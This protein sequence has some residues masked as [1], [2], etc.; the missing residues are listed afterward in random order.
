VVAG[1]VDCS[2]DPPSV[3]DGTWPVARHDPAGTRS[4]PAANGPAERPTRRWTVDTVETG[5]GVPVADTEAVYAFA[6]GGPVHPNGEDDHPTDAVAVRA[7]RSGTV[8]WRFRSDATGRGSLARVGSDVL[9]PLGTYRSV[10]VHRI[11]ATGGDDR[12]RIGPGGRRL[13]GDPLG[14]EAGVALPLESQISVVDADGDGCLAI[15]P[16]EDPRE[17]VRNR[18]VTDLVL[19]DGRAYVGTAS[20]DDD[21]LPA[22]VGQVVAV[23]GASVRWVRQLDA[24]VRALA[25]GDGVLVVGT[26]RE[27]LALAAGDGTERWRHGLGDRFRTLCLADG[28][29]V[30][31]TGAG[32]VAVEEGTERWRRSLSLRGH[33][34][35]VDGTVYVPVGSGSGSL[36]ALDLVAGSR[37]WRLAPDDPIR[38]VS[39]AHGHLYAGTADG[40]LLAYA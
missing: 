15:Y 26:D 17:H 23:D 22:D 40:R 35:A 18:A 33:P 28:T 24:P 16:G 21:V 39:A 6:S 10:A 36:L 30:V 2:L 31:G 7:D 3:P 27:V 32:V 14:L 12:G 19:A 5:T 25:A 34:I 13:G 37:R 29:V 8:D 38:A 11:S 9:V 1:T 4:A 20:H